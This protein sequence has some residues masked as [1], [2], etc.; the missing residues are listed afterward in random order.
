MSVCK[1]HPA[2]MTFHHCV[3]KWY[4]LQQFKTNSHDESQLSSK[5][6]EFDAI[7]HIITHVVYSLQVYIVD[8]KRY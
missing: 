1:D 7:H 4:H 5:G 8:A 3:G 2:G 6:Y